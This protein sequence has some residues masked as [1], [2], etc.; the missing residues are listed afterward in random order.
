MTN[1]KAHTKKGNFVVLK[2]Y[3]LMSQTI[4]PYLQYVYKSY[5]PRNIFF[6][7]RAAFCIEWN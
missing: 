1:F 2:V 5:R 6:G 3:L 4:I 7:Y